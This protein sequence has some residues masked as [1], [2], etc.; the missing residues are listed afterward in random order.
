ML[1]HF[2]KIVSQIVPALSAHMWVE[3]VLSSLSWP[4]RFFLYGLWYSPFP[5]KP[6]LT[7]FQFQPGMVNE[8]PLSGC[9]IIAYLFIY[10]SFIFITVNDKHLPHQEMI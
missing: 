6:T 4:E 3:Y 2:S 10:Y 8:E 7:K 1:E 5:Q 9:A